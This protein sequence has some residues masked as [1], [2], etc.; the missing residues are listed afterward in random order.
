MMQDIA[1]KIHTKINNGSTTSL[2]GKDSSSLDISYQ[3]VLDYTQRK[4]NDKRTILP[5]DISSLELHIKNAILK[6]G[7]G[8]LNSGRKQS[9]QKSQSPSRYYQDSKA[10]P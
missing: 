7:D 1:N 10:S 4:L 9:N 8:V 6:V 3:K 5:Q 2:N